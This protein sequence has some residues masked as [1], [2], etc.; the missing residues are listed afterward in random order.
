LGGIFDRVHLKPAAI[1]RAGLSTNRNTG[2]AKGIG[3]SSNPNPGRLMLVVIEHNEKAG[4][5]M[6]YTRLSIT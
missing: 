5:S 1:R 6:L 2:N 3:E 4:C